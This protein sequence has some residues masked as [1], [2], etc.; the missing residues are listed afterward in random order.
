MQCYS[1]IGKVRE[2]NVIQKETAWEHLKMARH[3]QNFIPPSIFSLNYILSLQISCISQLLPNCS[4]GQLTGAGLKE[5]KKPVNSGT[6]NGI[7]GIAPSNSLTH[8]KDVGHW[9]EQLYLSAMVCV[10][11]I[12]L[13]WWKV[14]IC[15]C[16]KDL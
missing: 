16:S 14:P 5:K 8:F 7:E 12:A 4:R 3:L 13:S 1:N 9:K 2:G 10:A 6:E 11:Y 15:V